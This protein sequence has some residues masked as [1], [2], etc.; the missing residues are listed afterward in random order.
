MAIFSALTA[1]T[2]LAGIFGLSCYLLLPDTV[3]NLIPASNPN[4]ETPIFM[5][6]GDRDPM[7]LPQWGQMS[8]DMLKKWSYKVDMH[9]Y[10]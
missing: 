6:H 5:G 1:P 2:Q 7:V 3:R 4:L 8:A 10:P 9:V